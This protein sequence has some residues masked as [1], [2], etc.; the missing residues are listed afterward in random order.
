MSDWPE[1]HKL[2]ADMDFEFPKFK[3]TPLKTI[4]KNASDEAIDLMKQMMRYNPLDR[5][6]AVECLQHSYFDDVRKYFEPT[7]KETPKM[8]YRGNH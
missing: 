8:Q 6:T 5:P 3:E 7:L 2:A 1:G 4:I